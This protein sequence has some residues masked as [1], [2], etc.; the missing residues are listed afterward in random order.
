[1]NKALRV[2]DYLGHILEAIERIEKYVSDM[3]EMAFL[4]SLQ[5]KSILAAAAMIQICGS[6]AAQPIEMGGVTPNKTTIAQLKVLVKNPDTLNDGPN[7]VFLLQIQRRAKVLI[8]K[9]LVYELEIPL[10]RNDKMIEVLLEKYG[11]PS[12]RNIYSDGDLCPGQSPGAFSRHASY[13]KNE[14]WKQKE[15]VSASIDWRADRCDQELT[16]YYLSMHVKTAF[17]EKALGL[18]K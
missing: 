2:P 9:N 11:K 5:V 3:D 1:M 8:R 4:A 12:Y 14:Q 16:P 10:T 18:A 15:G 6:A 13:V 17:R 7:D